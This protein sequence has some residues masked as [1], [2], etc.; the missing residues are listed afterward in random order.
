MYVFVRT[1]VCLLNVVYDVVNVSSVCLC[2][3]KQCIL[4]SFM[5]PRTS[6]TQ[7]EATILMCRML[8]ESS[9]KTQLYFFLICGERC[10]ME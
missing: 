2:A 8:C 6:C 10:L 1:R 3:Q 9:Y 7:T 4:Y 5:S